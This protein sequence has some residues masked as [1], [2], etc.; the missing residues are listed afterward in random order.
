MDDCMDDVTHNSHP[1]GQLSRKRKADGDDPTSQDYQPP[2][3]TTMDPIDGLLPILRHHRWSGSSDGRIPAP[4]LEEINHRVPTCRSRE[5]KRPKIQVVTTSETGNGPQQKR[6]RFSQSPSCKNGRPDGFPRGYLESTTRSE[7]PQSRRHQKALLSTI[8]LDS[9]YIPSFLP[10]P[11]RET[12]KELELE[13]V[14]SNPQLRHDLLFDSGLQFRPTSSRRK[15]SQAELYWSA[16]ARELEC[17]CTCLTWNEHGHMLAEPVCIC[18][19]SCSPPTHNTVVF[20]PNLRGKTLRTISRIRNLFSELLEI[21]LSIIQPT[22]SGILNSTATHLQPAHDKSV[23]QG[24]Y[25][26]SILDPELIQQE[27]Y[28][29][30]WDASGLFQILGETLKCHCAPMRD[31]SIETMIQTAQSCADGRDTTSLTKA[32]RMC[33]DVLEFMKLDL[34]NHRLQGLRPYLLR[35]APEY[36]RITFQDEK[37]R[38][39]M[40]LAITRSWVRRAFTQLSTATRPNTANPKAS[41]S[42]F[43]SLRRSVQINITVIKAIIDLVFNPRLPEIPSDTPLVSSAPH[44]RSPCLAV[45]IPE[46]LFLD[47]ARLRIYTTDAVDLTA[48][49]MLLLLY[50]QLVFSETSRSEWRDRGKAGRRIV[51]A[52]LT[53]LKSEIWAI[54]PPRLGWCFIP[55]ARKLDSL[56]IDSRNDSRRS[57]EYVGRRDGVRSRARS[58]KSEQERWRKGVRDVA[59]H[60]ASRSK[61][62][63]WRAEAGSTQTS[64]ISRLAALESMRPPPPPNMAMVGLVER[65]CES[66]LKHGSRLSVFLKEKL[67]DVMLQMVMACY[68]NVNNLPPPSRSTLTHLPISRQGAPGVP[69]QAGLIQYLPSDVVVGDNLGMGTLNVE[70]QGIAERIAKLAKIHVDVYGTMYGSEE[71]FLVVDV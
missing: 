29:G 13:A 33:F 6:K 11:N 44:S 15:R 55:E 25:I 35:S 17:R 10:I 45:E 52:E 26:R 28:R 71:G 3:P 38:E 49:Y 43:R 58:S 46:T 37:E 14:L 18:R 68:H 32:I 40:D 41:A 56:D 1:L 60:I 62:V 22:P 24:N 57:G 59:L 65:W 66:N 21:L 8:D 27:I 51:E 7:L 2:E 30:V 20:L 53:R 9:P 42:I 69:D 50:R 67:A 12:L 23:T 70:M 48:I 16:V 5:P 4:L 54:A 39:N 19:D 34:A 64:S 63:Q 31:R 61:D 36:E 47:V